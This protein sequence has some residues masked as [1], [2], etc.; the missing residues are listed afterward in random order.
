MQNRIQ[1]SKAKLRGQQFENLVEKS[2]SYYAH[3]KI[4]L[5]EKTPE[6]L[7]MIKR[8]RGSQVIAVFE[9]KGQPDFK[10]TVLGGQSV[11]FEAKH[12]SGARITLDRVEQ[13]QLA[14]LSLHKGLG[15]ECFILI[16]F[17][18]KSFYRV[19]IDDWEALPGALNKKSANEK[20]LT[21]YKVDVK[22]GVIDFLGKL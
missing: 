14:N 17:E 2:C 12:T 3:K 16:S 19:P 10:G 1:G 11:V 7:R 15:G 4:A 9:K 20:D 5:I 13:H 6:P 22:H 18:L 21:Q 8:G